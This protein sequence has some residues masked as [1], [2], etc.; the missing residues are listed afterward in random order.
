MN[1]L[2]KRL[3]R[4]YLDLAGWKLE[5]LPPE[6]VRKYVIIAAPHTSNW[7]GPAMLAMASVLGIDVNWMGKDDLFKPP[8][9]RFLKALGGISIDRSKDTGVVA[10]MVQRFEEADELVL[11]VPVSGTRGY[12]DHWKSGF[13]HIA[14]GANVP[15]CLSYLDFDSKRGGL[16]PCIELTGDMRADMD[17]IRAFYEGKRGLYPKK[18]SRVRLREEASPG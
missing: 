8:M 17:R 3:G 18:Q 7:D 5:G 12:A 10:Q 11:L 1:G 6:G 13:Y 14:K 16:G 15:V 2:K 9:G 4:A